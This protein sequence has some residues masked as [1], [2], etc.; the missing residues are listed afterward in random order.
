[1]GFLLSVVTIGVTLSFPRVQRFLIKILLSYPFEKVSLERVTVRFNGIILEDLE[2]KKDRWHFRIP[3]LTVDWNLGTLLCL[4]GFKIR[5]I[6]S[7]IQVD[8]PENEKLSSPLGKKPLFFSKASLWGRSPARKTSK[9]FLAHLQWPLKLWVEKLNVTVSGTWGTSK[10]IHLRLSGGHLAPAHEGNFQWTVSRVDGNPES[11][12][13]DGEGSVRLAQSPKGTLEGI[14]IEGQGQAQGSPW[15]ISLLMERTPHHIHTSEVFRARLTGGRS[16]DGEVTGQFLRYDPKTFSAQWQVDTDPLFLSLVAPLIPPFP[17]SA[18]GEIYRLRA[19]GNWSIKS[20]VAGWIEKDF[21]PP[22][23]LRCSWAGEW[24][25]SGFTLSLFRIGLRDRQTKKDIFK[26]LLLHPLSFRRGRWIPPSGDT[27]IL[28]G[29]LFSIPLNLHHPIKLPFNLNMKGQ[30]LEREFEISWSEKNKRWQLETSGPLDVRGLDVQAGE[31]PWLDHVTLK[32]EPQ[33]YWNKE[34]KI[35]RFRGQLLDKNYRPL[36]QSKLSFIWGSK[37][38]MSGKGSTKIDLSAWNQQPVGRQ[39]ILGNTWNNGPEAW[40]HYTFSGN[41]KKWLL[42]EAHFGLNEGLAEAHL[43]TPIP[44]HGLQPVLEDCKEGEV[45]RWRL[46]FFPLKI[47]SPLFRSFTENYLTGTVTYDGSLEK[48]GDRFYLNS[49]CPFVCKD[50]QDPQWIQIP[51]ASGIPHL[52]YHPQEGGLRV[53]VNDLLLGESPSSSETPYTPWITVENLVL[54]TDTQQNNVC[55]GELSLQFNGTSVVAEG[56][57]I[58]SETGYEAKIV[59][60][61]R[62]LYP[63]QIFTL[64]NL[65]RPEPLAEKYNVLR[66]AFDLDTRLSASVSPTSKEIWGDLQCSSTDGTVQLAK[67]QDP[68]T[69]TLVSLTG[70]ANALLGHPVKWVDTLATLYPYFKEIPYR[71]LEVELDRKRHDVIRLKKASLKNDEIHFL[72]DGYLEQDPHKPLNQQ[73]LWIDTTIKVR[74]GPLLD[75]L[76]LDHRDKEGYWTGP[77]CVLRGTLKN[78][79][80]SDFAQ[81]L[82]RSSTLPDVPGTATNAKKTLENLL[83]SIF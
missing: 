56:E 4:R 41:H 38:Q 43:S 64:Y 61:I 58:P 40:C 39:Y 2:M 48:R 8:R 62:N 59:S 44:F 47:L 73:S 75:H 20:T 54:K 21:L 12:V 10:K 50:L 36:V 13:L 19:T 72:A 67:D 46:K 5:E 33:I 31:A 80:T 81:W 66:G 70:M 55:S 30:I 77:H 32:M 83:R 23:T 60:H 18:S 74:K 71:T 14:H 37:T 28:A 76:D 69:Q 29:S 24:G 25:K 45:L 42:S 1:M 78:L 79:D 68:T 35:V 26:T 3:H 16:T 17:L 57:R 65:L 11:K 27:K 52:D 6:R 7:H 53:Q 34:R 9:T 82:R 63:H 15:K 22:S 49:I 51:Y